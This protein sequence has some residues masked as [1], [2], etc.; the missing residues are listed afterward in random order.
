MKAK[1]KKMPKQNK[2]EK[3][4]KFSKAPKDDLEKGK[5]SKKGLMKKGKMP[6]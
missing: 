4:V 6:C 2:P 1:P 3:D 5:K